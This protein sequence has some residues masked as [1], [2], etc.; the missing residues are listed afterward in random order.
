MKY[1]CEC[2]ER[3]CPVCG[4]RLRYHERKAAGL[5]KPK[6]NPRTL[7]VKVPRRVNPELGKRLFDG[8]DDDEL[9]PGDR[10]MAR[11]VTGAERAAKQLIKKP[12]KKTWSIR[13]PEY[14]EVRDHTRLGLEVSV[15]KEGKALVLN[16][17]SPSQET[18]IQRIPFNRINQQGN[19]GGKE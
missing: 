11:V 7:D 14:V 15:S 5:V 13:M 19:N 6:V 3:K 4:P 1:K 9:T 18:G 17:S 10:L 12:P 16:I 8:L 2:N